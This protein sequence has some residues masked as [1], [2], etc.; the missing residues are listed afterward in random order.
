MSA[1]RAVLIGTDGR[2]QDLACDGLRMMQRAVGGYIDL[3]FLTGEVSGF[4]N[5]EG[6][7]LPPN[8]IAGR[9]CARLGLRLRQPVFGPLLLVGPPSR[10]GDETD[11]PD[12]V[13]AV[14][15]EEARRAEI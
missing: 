4:V 10:H 12:G 15:F 14:A 1:F 6:H 3:L 2:V 8:R 13:R 9:V 11:C 5:E 7:G